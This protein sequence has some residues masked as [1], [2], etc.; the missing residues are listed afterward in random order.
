MINQ[1]RVIQGGN[2]PLPGRQKRSPGET[3]LALCSICKADTGVAG[4]TWIKVT[5]GLKIRRGSIGGGTPGWICVH[6]L[7]RGKITRLT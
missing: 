5:M 7:T 6:C 2:T 4:N 1:F 3:E